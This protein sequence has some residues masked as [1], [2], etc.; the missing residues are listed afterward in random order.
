MRQWQLNVSRATVLNLIEA[1]AVHFVNSILVHLKAFRALCFACWL[2][3][4]TTDTE[5]SDSLSLS[6]NNMDTIQ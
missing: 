6:Q 5:S 3:S 1:T 4:A 2:E